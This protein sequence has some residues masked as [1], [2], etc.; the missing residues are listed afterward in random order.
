MAGGRRS[1]VHV[2]DVVYV[3]EPFYSSIEMA[4]IRRVRAA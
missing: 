4:V 2:E 1:R 3:S